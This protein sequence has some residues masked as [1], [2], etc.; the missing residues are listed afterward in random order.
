MKSVLIIDCGNYNAV[1]TVQINYIKCLIRE[2]FDINYIIFNNGNKID[3]IKFQR[4]PQHEKI[5]YIEISSNLI[6]IRFLSKI[7]GAHLIKLFQVYK[8]LKHVKHTICME[9]YSAVPAYL[10][11]LVNPNF[12][13]QVASLELYN[14]GSPLAMKAMQQSKLITTQDELRKNQILKF[15]KIQ[16]SE[17]IQVLYNTSLSWEPITTEKVDLPVDIQGQKIILFIGSLITEHCIEEVI[18]WVEIID[19]NYTIVFHGWGISE[20]N[21]LRIVE[22]EKKYPRKVWLSNIVLS[23]EEKWKIYNVADIGIV[24]FNSA[25]R[26]NEF[27][28][29]SAGKLFD[30]IR[31]GIPVFVS[32]TKL[33]SSFVLENKFGLVFDNKNSLNQK[34]RSLADSKNSTNFTMTSFDINFKTVLNC[35][36]NI[37]E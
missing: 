28:G 6:A 17:K 7:I 27:A 33:L 25:I 30:F 13:Y 14:N 35:L 4:W 20:E 21:K 31:L 18:N 2:G 15:Y 11:S 29:L 8:Y 5:N 19:D 34:L 24:M 16:R 36:E 32:N 37:K 12:T 26:N 1:T 22:L 3:N 10:F 23:E 9:Y